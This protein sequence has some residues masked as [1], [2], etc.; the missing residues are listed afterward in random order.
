MRA[1]GGLGARSRAFRML[2]LSLALGVITGLAV[3]AIRLV[4]YEGIWNRIPRNGLVVGVFPAVGLLL[5]GL[6][7][8]YFTRSDSPHD[9]EAYIEVYHA[10]E[11]DDW[12]AAV[13]KTAAAICTVGFGGAAGLEGPSMYV[14]GTLGARLRAALRRLGVADAR[15]MRSLVVAGAAAGISAVFKAPLT[16]LVFA[17]EVPYTDDFAREALVPAL[18]SSVASYLTLVSI[19]GPEPLFPVD[20]ALEPS[21]V[22]LALAVALG[23]LLGL[24]ARVLSLSVLA[25]ERVS[26]KMRVPLAVRTLGGGVV[27]GLLGIVTLRAFG[28]PLA[29]GSGYEI[30]NGAVI[31][32]FVGVAALVLFALRSV[33]VV[34]TLGSGA[35]GGTFIPFMSMGAAAGAVFEDLLPRSGALFPII[36]MAAFL[37]A[38]NATPIAAAVFVAESTGSTGYVVPGVVAATAAYLVSGGRSISRNQR[39]SRREV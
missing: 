25:A 35:A 22:S 13:A 34:A 30:I 17:M 5:S 29:L 6:L 7:L 21:L 15:A 31:G 38:A 10:G 24:V 12:R 16:G 11:A 39:P 18:V 23:A 4:V 1:A 32:R 19:L 3:V 9:T 26:A 27:C 2:P 37:A 14:G 33:A 36:R 28:E 8:Q 20:R